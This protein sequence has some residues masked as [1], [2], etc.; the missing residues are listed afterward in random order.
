MLVTY[1]FVGLVATLL[2][3]LGAFA[4]AFISLHNLKS[5]LDTRDR[6]LSYQLKE[7]KKEQDHHK[8]WVLQPLKDLKREQEHH[9]EWVLLTYNGL[10]ERID[11]VQSRTKAEELNIWTRLG[12][13][14]QFL[15]KTTPFDVRSS[16][17]PGN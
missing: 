2:A 8:E 5:S 17:K 7:L 6:E 4:R 9:K 10:Q 14:E 1:E 11:H 13:V 16:G 12:A 3:I 15:S